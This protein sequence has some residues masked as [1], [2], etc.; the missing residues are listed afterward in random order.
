MRGRQQAMGFQARRAGCTGC[1]PSP[2]SDPAGDPPGGGQ[3]FVCVHHR[4]PRDAEMPG[5]GACG[6]QPAARGQRS[7]AD[8]GGDC[9]AE[10]A[11]QA[12]FS[13]E[14]NVEQGR[15]QSRAYLNS[16][17]SRGAGSGTFD[18]A[19]WLFPIVPNWAMLEGT[20]SI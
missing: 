12:Q 3:L 16:I 10:L 13:V 15:F 4:V 8:G 6:W 14:L 11:V 19:E 9:V 17:T 18:T 1:D 20:R 2:R 7:T 5:Q